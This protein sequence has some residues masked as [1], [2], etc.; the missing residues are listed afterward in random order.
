VP[1]PTSMSKWLQH[2]TATAGPVLLQGE[3]QPLEGG[4][5][6]FR[7]AHNNGIQYSFSGAALYTGIKKAAC[8]GGS[9]TTAERLD[10]LYVAGL[11]A[12]LTLSHFKANALTFSECFEA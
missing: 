6:W 3:N 12:F 5:I 8:E 10:R 9:F 1:A 4:D 11:W 2:D 7:G